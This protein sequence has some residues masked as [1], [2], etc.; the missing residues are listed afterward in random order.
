MNLLVTGCAGFI[1]SHL[2]GHLLKLGHKV[3]GVDNLSTGFSH[4]IQAMLE[5]LSRENKKQFVFAEED[6]RSFKSYKNIDCVFHLAAIGSV[7]RS[8]KRPDYTHRNNVDGFFKVL[9]NARKN[10]VGRVIYSSSSSVYGDSEELIK[11]EYELGRQ[12]S[13]YSA[14]K[15]INEIQ[16]ESFRVCYGMTVI[17]LRYF[18]VYGPRQNPN[19]AYAAVIPRWTQ[20]MIE[21]RDIIIYGDGDQTRDFTYVQDVVKANY[22]AIHAREDV[23][24][25]SGSVYNVGTGNRT[26]LNELFVMLS[27]LTGY[28]KK[29][30]HMDERHGDRKHSCASPVLASWA[31]GFAAQTSLEQGLELTIYGKTEKV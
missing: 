3:I 30:I 16:A 21:N 29:P 13:P 17:G 22:F 14:S 10:N 6:V 28:E 7:P 1:G 19:G 18:N 23:L 8:V 27:A 24:N 12:V 25:A 4:N 11:N 26:R 15:R 20:A 31:L 5:P 2:T 9:N